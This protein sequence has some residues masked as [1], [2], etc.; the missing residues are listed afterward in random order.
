[1]SFTFKHEQK[2]NYLLA[3]IEG[4]FTLDSAMLAIEETFKKCIE[5]NLQKILVDASRATG[6]LT[7]MDRYQ[8]GEAFAEIQKQYI[9]KSGSK[10]RTVIYARSNLIEEKKFGETVGLNR[11]ANIKVT[12]DLAE[13]KSWLDI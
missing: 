12:T 10:L 5:L 11:G 2:E 7:T 4:G 6:N 8:F 1:M 9:L 3:V 13:A